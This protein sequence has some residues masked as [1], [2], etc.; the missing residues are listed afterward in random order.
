MCTVIGLLLLAAGGW[1]LLQVG[2][3]RCMFLVLSRA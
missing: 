1:Q 3:V 2:I